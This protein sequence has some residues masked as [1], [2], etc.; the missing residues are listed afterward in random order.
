MFPLL[1]S[2]VPAADYITLHEALEEGSARITEVSKEGRVPEL[3]F[4]NRL[5]L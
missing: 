1:G 3:R 4:L 5:D 2:D